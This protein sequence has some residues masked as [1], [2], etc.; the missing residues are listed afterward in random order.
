MS[1]KAFLKTIDSK[2]SSD[3]HVHKN[4]DHDFQRHHDLPE[5]QWQVKPDFIYGGPF[6]KPSTMAPFMDSG[7][8][9]NLPLQGTFKKYVH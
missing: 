2:K 7:T 6:I 8:P 5:V 9:I 1:S 4:S 3:D